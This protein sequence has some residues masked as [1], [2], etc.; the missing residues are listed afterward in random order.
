M[1]MNFVE[2]EGFNLIQRD[3]K[4]ARNCVP[5]LGCKSVRILDFSLDESV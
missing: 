1:Q 4:Y 5:T 3:M 2:L